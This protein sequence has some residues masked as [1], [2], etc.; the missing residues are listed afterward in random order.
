[1]SEA[2][3]DVKYKVRACPMESAEASQWVPLLSKGDGSLDLGM[4][5]MCPFVINELMEY[6]RV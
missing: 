2:D 3:S 1:M 6:L 4:V 5:V